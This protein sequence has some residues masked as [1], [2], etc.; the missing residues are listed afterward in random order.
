[1]KVIFNDTF[2]DFFLL[3][4]IDALF[5]TFGD[6]QKLFVTID[7]SNVFLMM[8]CSCFYTFCENITI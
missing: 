7:D 1:M 5:I 6:G 8:I 3:K 4:L 2:S